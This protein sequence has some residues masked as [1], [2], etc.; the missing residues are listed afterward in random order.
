MA[1]AAVVT[2]SDALKREQAARG[3]NQTAAATLIGVERSVYSKWING[4]G[5]VPSVH[6]LPAVAKFLHLTETDLLALFP[7]GYRMRAARGSSVAHLAQ[8]VAELHD[9]ATEV[10]ELRTEVADLRRN[11]NGKR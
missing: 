8:L 2:I 4:R 1:R 9:L 11:S 10:R 6:N 5:T 3:I 7:A